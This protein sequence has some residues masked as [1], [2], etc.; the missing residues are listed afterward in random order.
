MPQTHK[1]ASIFTVPPSLVTMV[2]RAP[3]LSSVLSPQ[4]VPQSLNYEFI[5]G[6]P[7]ELFP[8]LSYIAIVPE[9]QEH[10]PEAHTDKQ[11]RKPAYA[12]VGT[13]F[14]M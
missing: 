1:E 3:H 9:S 10:F 2:T 14:F 12:H 4:L 5:E 7:K 8:L 11:L 6:E 13:A